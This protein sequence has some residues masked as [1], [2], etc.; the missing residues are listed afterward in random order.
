MRLSTAWIAGLMAVL[1]L[2]TGDA[3]AAGGRKGKL[4][5][6]QYAYSAAIRWGDFEGAWSL[7]DPKLR[8]AAPL[9]DLQLERFKQI[10]VSGY[11]EGA[12]RV[13][14]T[15]AARDVQIRVINRHTMA[16]RSLRYREVWEWDP[17]AKT[18]WVTSGLPDFWA[19]Q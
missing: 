19:G 2:V 5:Q 12:G 4:E 16:E 11:D 13:E 3:S 1:L 6:L 8:E 7:L 14:K 10:Q 9:T 15:A 18:W 17:Q